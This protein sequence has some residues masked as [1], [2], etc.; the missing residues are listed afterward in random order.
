MNLQTL[1]KISSKTQLSTL[2]VSVS[3]ILIEWNTVSTNGG[4]Q[5]QI[6]FIQSKEGL[7]L[8]EMMIRVKPLKRLWH[9]TCT[10][11]T[12]YLHSKHDQMELEWPDY[13]KINNKA[14]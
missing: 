14:Q 5:S 12:A 10:G 8:C 6:D 13:K 3:N 9:F 1:L 7:F 11:K 2:Q 4:V